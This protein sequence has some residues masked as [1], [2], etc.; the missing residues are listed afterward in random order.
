MKLFHVD[1]SPKYDWSNSRMLAR[2]FLERLRT[3]TP[4]IEVDYLDLARDVPPHPTEMFTVA[5]YTPPQD[6]T[7]EMAGSLAVSDALCRRLLDADAL[8]FA[9]P[10]HNFTIPSAFKTFI[11]N[12]VRGWLTYEVLPDG[13]YLGH[14]GDKQVLFITTR[15]TDLRPGTP[16][17]DY[18]ALTPALRSAFG[19]IGVAEPDFVDAQ[20]LQ[21]ADQAAREE[22]IA[23][24]KAELDS[25]AETWAGDVARQ[26]FAATA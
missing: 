17:A 3:R 23:R 2:Y 21:F 16:F 14:L 20:P 8:L 26:P 13:Q 9:M 18:D 11:D 4:H 19:F 7:P 1:A 15:G 10:M 24:A 25:L 6:R 5:M 22:A 12:I